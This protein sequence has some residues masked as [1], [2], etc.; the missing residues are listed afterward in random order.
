MGIDI[1]EIV[2][3]EEDEFYEAEEGDDMAKANHFM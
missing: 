3:T 2:P 1:E